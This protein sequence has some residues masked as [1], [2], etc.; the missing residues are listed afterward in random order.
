MKLKDTQ[1]RQAKP[2]EKTYRLPDGGGLYLVVSPSGNKYWQHRYK[3]QGKGKTKSYGPYPAISLL[4][5]RKELLEDKELLAKRL[6]PCRQHQLEKQKAQF[7]LDNTFEAVA[8]AWHE[9]Q[10][11]RWKEKQAKGVINSLERRVFPEIGDILLN[12]IQN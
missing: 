8:R 7:E 3:T 6:D 11:R 5:A 10:A 4:Q 2:K 12:C 1:L 9:S